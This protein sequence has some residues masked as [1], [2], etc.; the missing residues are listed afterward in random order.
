MTTTPVR[1]N[2]STKTL[3]DCE[4]AFP[5]FAKIW[6]TIKADAGTRIR[7]PKSLTFTTAQEQVILNDGECARRYA[8]K[9]DT[10][11]LSDSRH[12]SSGDW[13]VHAGSNNDQAV[14]GIPENCAVVT[15]SWQD[16]HRYGSMTFQVAKLPELLG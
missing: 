13:A 8:L 7:C 10:L 4:R 16:Y 15:F 14:Q 1:H 9:L 2:V 6:R 12:V 5:G 3:A 11:E